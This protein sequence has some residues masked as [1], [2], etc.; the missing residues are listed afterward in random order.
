MV[1][2]ALFARTGGFARDQQVFQSIITEM[3]SIFGEN[4]YY[5]PRTIGNYDPLLSEDASSSYDSAYLI[6][7]YVKNP[8][9]GFGGKGDIMSMLGGLTID[10]T[11]TFVVSRPRWTQDVGF[12]QNNQS[13]PFEGDLIFLP[14][15]KKIYKVTF[16]EHESVFYQMGTLQVWELQ[17][18]LF[19]SSGEK[20]STGIP[21]IDALNGEYDV[22][23]AGDGIVQEDGSGSLLDELN[24]LPL[25]TEDFTD[26]G[27]SQL[28]DINDYLDEQG[29]D[30]L[31]FSCIDP[32]VAPPGTEN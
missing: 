14:L 22:N 13:R 2:N 30:L 10:D 24:G 6:D 28:Q 21:D 1:K 19:T 20:F 26:P 11:I 32:M 3:I 29:G 31:D 15:N 25:E 7:M 9:A 4:V 27:D 18:E 23:I 5:V 12:H 16:V 8:A 17:C